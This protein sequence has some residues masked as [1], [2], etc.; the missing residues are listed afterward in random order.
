MK[1]TLIEIQNNFQDYLLDQS[2]PII[3]EIV[4]TPK[5]Q[6]QTRMDVYENAYRLRLIETL[7]DNFIGLNGLA[8]DVQFEKIARQYID[9]VPST[10]KNI[11]WYGDHL[12][13]FLRDTTPWNTEPT[14][15]E[16][17]DVDWH[18]LLAFD[19]PNAVRIDEQTIM[20]LP[21]QAWESLR[22]DFH[23]SLNRLDVSHNVF[24]FRKQLL[25]ESEDI[26]A[27]E[28]FE[29]L[30]AWVIWRHQL[31]QLYRSMDVDEAWA[32]D[33]AMLGTSFPVLCEGL[34]EWIDPEHAAA[35]AAGFLK[36]WVT[37]GLIS[38][39]KY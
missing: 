20:S 12:A 17:A 29:Y 18:I 8:G 16:M 21:A 7:T 30:T 10:H 11:R 2:Q 25:S 39:V 15:A 5:I 32:L 23:P 36:Q 19:A 37:D 33:Q 9:A 14:L 22:F 38:A 13:S 3:A 27:P 35:R 34:C 1:P 6:A 28:K 26:A 31:K 24:K 4:S